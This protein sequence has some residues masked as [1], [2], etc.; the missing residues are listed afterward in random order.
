MRNIFLLLAGVLVSV[1]SGSAQ[2]QR[3][4]LLEHFTQASCGPCAGIN[5]TIHNLL[6]NNPTKITSVYY[7]TSW[8]GYD[9]M[10]NHN[11]IDV[12]ARVS[13]YGV[14]YVPWSVLDG[15]YYSGSASGW[16]IN[17][18]NARYAMPSPLAIDMQHTIS[19]GQDSVYLTMLLKPSLPI[20]GSLVAHSVVIEKHIHYNTPPGSNGEKDFYNVMKKMLPGKNG[21]TIP[22]G[23]DLGDY[24]IIETSW[25]FANVYTV[26]EIAGVGF[27]QNNSGKEVYQSTNS[28]TNA[29][30]TLYDNDAEVLSI[31]EVPLSNCMGKVMPVIQLRN[32]GNQPLTEATINYQ[33]N[34]GAV[35]TMNWIGNLNLLKKTLITLPEITFTPEANNVL[36][37][38]STQPNG[39]A[40]EYPKND[41]LLF[42]F[43]GA[44]ITST[45]VIFA[46]RTDLNPGQ[47]TYELRDSTNT[48]IYSGGPYPNANTVYKDTFELNINQC[49]H[50]S[51]FDAG[52][53]GV[54]CDHGN[55]FYYLAD[56]NGQMIYQGG[57]FGFSEHHEFSTLITSVND[58]EMV[59]F[60]HLYPNPVSGEATVELGLSKGNQV[61]LTIHD[62]YGKVVARPMNT[63]L[64]DGI[65]TLPIDVTS[66]K[67]GIY[68][69]TVKAGNTKKVLRFS[70]LE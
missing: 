68:L 11:P 66:L 12:N 50:F 58:P 21:T 8:P 49:Y 23:L 38:F 25:P 70:V 5:P 60:I 19:A 46:V 47:V 7:H 24:M 62:M 45:K 17:T 43:T 51:I 20:T 61:E 18:V 16:N 44:K 35:Q 69:M 22:A 54:C 15:N 41:T 67:P 52:G 56:D 6:V 32:N 10:Y 31:K 63:F 42:T 53:N 30:V 48:V 13:Y 59:S 40:D 3:L 27:V 26:S 55:G 14:T 34:G 65:H 1:I 2:D 64:G 29:V 57:Q 39:V 33:V 37:V 28:S 4:V 36:K 9:P